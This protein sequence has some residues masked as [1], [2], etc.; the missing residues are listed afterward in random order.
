MTSSPTHL[1]GV[2]PV[3]SVDSA[4]SARTAAPPLSPRLY[5]ADLAPT[6]IELGWVIANMITP[7]SLGLD[8]LRLAVEGRLPL[9][10]PGLSEVDNKILAD[11]F[12][13]D[14]Q[15]LLDAHQRKERLAALQQPILDVDLDPLGIDEAGILAIGARL[16]DQ[17]AE[18]IRA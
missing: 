15:R 6:K 5:S 3:Q 16:S 18:E 4:A 7:T 11:Q 2:T 17:L 10:V 9:K 14:A 8:Q 12:A 13:T 1:S